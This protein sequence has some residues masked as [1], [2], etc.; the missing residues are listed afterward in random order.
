MMDGFRFEIS[1]LINMKKERMVI[2]RNPGSVLSV[3]FDTCFLSSVYY[4]IPYT[5][6]KK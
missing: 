5:K 1:G 6:K 3:I 4:I 2:E